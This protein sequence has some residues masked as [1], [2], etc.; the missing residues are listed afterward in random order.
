MPELPLFAER[1]AAGFPSPAQGYMDEPLDLNRLC[2]GEEAATFLLRVEGESMTG[3]GIF[4]GD[5]LVVDRAREAGHGDIVV[6]AV[7][8]AF[9]VKELQLS[10]EPVLLPHNPRHQPLYLEGREWELFGVATFSV[11]ALDRR[12]RAR[13]CP[14]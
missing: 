9:T 2:L 5:I 7:D 10:P 14:G 13:V 8:G 6:V 1:I 3:A 12:S 11:H 4:P